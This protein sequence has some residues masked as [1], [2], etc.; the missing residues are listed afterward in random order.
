M[1]FKY[2]FVLE[3]AEN[4]DDFVELLHDF[5]FV[6]LRYLGLKLL[7]QERYECFRRLLVLLV[8]D[9]LKRKLDR[10]IN[11]TVTRHSLS[12]NTKDSLPQ[13]DELIDE[14]FHFELFVVHKPASLVEDV[15]R[16]LLA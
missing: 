2:V 15:L 13:R 16:Q 7:V 11:L 9:V 3:V 14:L 10:Q 12:V 1:G 5:L 4:L 6:G 8:D